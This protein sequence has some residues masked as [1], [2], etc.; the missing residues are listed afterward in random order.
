MP[1]RW[2]PKIELTGCPK[3][4]SYECPYPPNWEIVIGGF[5][6]RSLAIAALKRVKQSLRD[7]K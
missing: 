2:K 4:T 3:H 6:T 1:Q 7:T 5:P